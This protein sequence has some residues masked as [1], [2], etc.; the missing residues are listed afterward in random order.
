VPQ[1]CVGFV[2]QLHLSPLSGP[3]GSL[4]G[5]QLLAHDMHHAGSGAIYRPA[6]PVSLLPAMMGQDVGESNR[7]TGA[8][9][10]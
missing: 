3:S 6:S 8:Q 7:A 2:L 10:G 4:I 9:Q 5:S 1:S